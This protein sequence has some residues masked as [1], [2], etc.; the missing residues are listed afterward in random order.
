MLNL[1]HHAGTVNQMGR[2]HPAP[3]GL[4]VTSQDTTPGSLGGLQTGPTPPGGPVASG[5]HMIS[6]GPNPGAFNGGL[7]A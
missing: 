7:M 6:G 2:P 3:S 4:N 5:I 1:P